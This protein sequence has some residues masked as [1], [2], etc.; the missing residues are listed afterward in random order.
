MNKLAIFGNPI[1]HSLSPQIHA[2]FAAQCSILLDY[3]K[4]LVPPNQF[5]Q[6]AEQ[7]IASGGIGFNVT[8]PCKAIAYHWLT[9]HSERARQ[10]GAVNTVL[11]RD[12]QWLG[13]NTDGIGFLRDC[14]KKQIALSGETIIVLGS[15][16]AAQ[17]IIPI[18]LS[19]HPARLIVVQ[20]DQQKKH[21]LPAFQGAELSLTESQLGCATAAG[22]TQRSKN[23]GSEQMMVVS[24]EEVAK[25][26]PECTL[27]ID[28]TSN[29]E[30]LKDT[31]LANR[32]WSKK[33]VVYDLKYGLAKQ[34]PAV[35]WAQAQGLQAY[36]GLGML[37]EQAAEAFYQW[38]GVYP[39]VE[40]VTRGLLA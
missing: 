34:T 17:G 15:G 2:Q 38:F 25:W 28:A 16:G 8:L 23:D 27:I 18:L 9:D 13:D 10:A 32:A 35:L 21:I 29:F 6:C 14:Q 33:L 26:L 37:I 7:F 20:R 30:V 12:G 39:A 5:Q 1:A 40:Q 24:Y 11:C 19:A 36:D 4:I 31:L 22:V 3:Q